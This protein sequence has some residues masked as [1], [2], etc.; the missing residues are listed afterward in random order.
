MLSIDEIKEQLGKEASQLVQQD[1]IIGIGSG[2]TAFY[3][4]NALAERVQHG[5]NCTAVPTSE[6]TRLL[7]EQKGIKLLTLNDITAIDLTIDGA[8]EIDLHLHIIKGGGGALLQEK[9]VAAA[10]KQVV[11]IAD[12]T[13]LVAQ[14]R[15][16]PLPIEVIPYGWKQVQQRIEKM[17]EIK[18]QL[19]KKNNQPFITDHGHYILDCYFQQIADTSG[20]NT[21]LHLI[22]GVVETGLFINMVDMAIIGYPD[23]SFKRLSAERN[24]P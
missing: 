15:H 18:I 1:M 17:H 22:P 16:F 8:D 14:S 11:I 20:L 10:S 5:L 13:K 9:M 7:A 6:R 2:T 24:E 4:I 21:S 12:H 23:G 3:L 19:R